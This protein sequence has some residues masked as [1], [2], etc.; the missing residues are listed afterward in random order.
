M[1]NGGV[2]GGKAGWGVAAERPS[3]AINLTPLP[4]VVKGRGTT[5]GPPPNL[6]TDE[7]EIHHV[8]RDE[9]PEP[10]VRVKWFAQLGSGVV[11]YTRQQARARER[12]V[13]SW[14]KASQQCR[15]HWFAEKEAPLLVVAVDGGADSERAQ[16]EAEEFVGDVVVGDRPRSCTPGTAAY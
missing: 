10:C 11:A 5:E 14:F 1:V 7:L 9:F 3:R 13:A 6:E 2:D 15:V 12:G 4:A 8:D 16:G